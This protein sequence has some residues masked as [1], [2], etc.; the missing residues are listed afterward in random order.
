M[1][2]ICRNTTN[3]NFCSINLCGHVFHQNCLSHCNDNNCPVCRISFTNN[4]ITRLYLNTTDNSE[5]TE[6]S[7]DEV[8]DFINNKDQEQT[9]E[10]N[11]NLNLSA[12]TITKEQIISFLQELGNS[13]DSRGYLSISQER[14]LLKLI[15]YYGMTNN[16]LDI[17][18]NGM[19][20]VLYNKITHAFELGRH[21]AN[22]GT[23]LHPNMIFWGDG[24]T[25]I[26]S[27]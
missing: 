27:N 18:F 5:L 25:H 7:A 9:I 23:H 11:I 6:L 21:I 13:S 3:S 1:C 17:S 15:G 26:L 14:E 19:T 22:H 12:I 8:T 24:I 20:P 2:A 10:N 4:D 16:Y